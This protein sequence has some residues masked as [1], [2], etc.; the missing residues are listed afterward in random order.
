MITG[1]SFDTAEQSLMKK[2][3]LCFGLVAERIGRAVAGE[4]RKKGN[5]ITHVILPIVGVA[6][7]VDASVLSA[8]VLAEYPVTGPGR[9]EVLRRPLV[10]FR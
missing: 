5:V 9:C 10:S 7:L 8:V 3:V 4:M 2:D 1:L 6:M